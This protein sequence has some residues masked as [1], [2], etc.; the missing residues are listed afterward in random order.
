MSE[1]ETTIRAL[2][3]WV[4]AHRTE[5]LPAPMIEQAKLL[6]LDTIGCAV[7]ALGEHEARATV[8]A[9]TALGGAPQSTVIGVP[10]KSSVPNAVLANGALLRFLDLNDYLVDFDADGIAM[11]GHPSDNIAVALAAG[12][13]RDRPGA[14]V[15]AAVAIGYEIYGRMKNLIDP[16]GPWD[17]TSASGM[18]APAMA[19]RLMGLDEGRLAHALALGVARAATP[20]VMRAGDISAGK[21]LANA[22]IA[23]SGVQ[24]AML[25]AGG[26]TGPLE[27]LDHAR[28][29]GTVFR[30][31]RDFSILTRPL[32]EDGALMRSHVKAFPCLATGQ[33]TVA[34][35]IRIH[36]MLRGRTD[37]IERINVTMAD[38]SVIRRQQTDPGRLDPTSREAADHSFPFLV[39]VA[40]ADG[41]LTPRQFDHE[42]W[43]ERAIRAL[44]ARTTLA[45]DPA[46]NEAGERG[47]PCVVRVVTRDGTEH[48]AEELEMPGSAAGG[49]DRPAVLDKFDALASDALGAGRRDMVKDSALGLERL[50]S[51]RPLMA[52]LGAGARLDSTARGRS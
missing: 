11:G 25:A 5:A 4:S 22:L 26:V 37:A 40:L 14:E 13:W 20:A 49:I 46:L 48:V 44:M 32:S 38:T 24:A 50:S 19:G 3:R 33:T 47:H 21:Y 42:R 36:H 51:I 30:P 12:E 41:R 17:G 29:L 8:E 15:L 34:A 52:A 45:T 28:G 18:A 6:I 31:D 1:Q 43:N 9:V 16:A 2:A 35:A 27:A 10:G 39:A 7:A 23:Q